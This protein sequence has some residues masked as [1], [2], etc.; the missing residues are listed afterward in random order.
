[1]PLGERGPAFHNLPGVDGN[2]YSMASFADRRILVLI[3]SSNRCPTVKAY[4]DRM[5]TLQRDYG[6]KGVQLVA[7]NSNNPYLY[8]DESF[9]EMVRRA[10][11]KGFSFP[12]LQ[13]EDQGVARGYGAVCTFHLFLL[14]EAR[15][16]R[17]RGRFDDS[18]NPA[19][20]ANHDLRNA[21]DDVLG[22]REVRV[23]DTV[24]FGCSLDYM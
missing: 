17:Y 12:Y 23:P 6:G 10:R 9:A 8:P 24:P 7:I 18:R 20:V 22:G 19:K 16:L 3:F 5:V 14:D 21:L 2:S 15:R 4:E 13:D 1:M 11:E